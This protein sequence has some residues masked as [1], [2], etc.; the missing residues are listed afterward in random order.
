MSPVG[1]IEMRIHALLQ[2][3]LSSVRS[4]YS[5]GRVRLIDRLRSVTP[6]R[7]QQLYARESD[8]ERGARSR[9]GVA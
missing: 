3:R 7:R 2:R 6:E 4:R 1:N 8:D 5:V 9:C